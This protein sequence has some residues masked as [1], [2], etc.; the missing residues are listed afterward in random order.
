MKKHNKNKIVFSLLSS[1][2]LVFHS[3]CTVQ[4]TVLCSAG[5]CVVAMVCC[6]DFCCSAAGSIVLLLPLSSPCSLSVSLCP[7]LYIY[8]FILCT[9]FWSSRTL[10][11]SFA[12]KKRK[13]NGRASVSFIKPGKP[14]TVAFLFFVHIQ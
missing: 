5:G 7:S 9:L 10:P 2:C 3:L 4:G 13:K 8:A 1:N 11:N 6:V 12:V 14:N